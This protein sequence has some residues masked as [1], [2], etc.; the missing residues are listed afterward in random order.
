MFLIVDLFDAKR[1][2]YT[3]LDAIRYDVA[4]DESCRKKLWGSQ[5]LI[6]RNAKYF[7]QLNVKDLHVMPRELDKFADECQMVN[8]EST[9]IAAEV[10]QDERK[11]KVI[12][13]YV[14]ARVVYAIQAARADHGSAG[15][16][17]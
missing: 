11:T 7:P 8:E 17:I 13:E 6:A 15:V 16:C 10:Y 4:G 5:S 2:K 1:G 12:E 3:Y 9:A 14:V